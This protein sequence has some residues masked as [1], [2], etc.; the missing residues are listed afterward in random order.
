MSTNLEGVPLQYPLRITQHLLPFIRTLRRI[1]KPR[2]A[3]P[4]I[5]P[6]RTFI[7][8]PS[9]HV[10]LALSSLQVALC[11]VYLGSRGWTKG[12]GG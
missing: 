7:G 3:D 5:A 4:T 11:V 1:S 8:A 10:R 2:L 12:K 9:L 6:S